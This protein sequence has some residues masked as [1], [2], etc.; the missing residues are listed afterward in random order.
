MENNN[1]KNK[2]KKKGVGK[3]IALTAVFFVICF[4]GGIA[5][6][7]LIQPNA[8]ADTVTR[9]SGEKLEFAL[10]AMVSM[11]VSYILTLIIHEGGH[12][13][14]GLATG[15]KFL[16]FRVF[17]LTLVKKDGKFAWKRFSIQGT[18]GQ[19]ILM[20]PED[21]A[22][23]KAPFLFYHLGGGLF[24]FITAA[25]CLPLVKGISAGIPKTALAVL[26]VFSA[27]QGLLNLIPMKIQVPNDG[28][29]ILMMIRN[30]ADRAAIYKSLY[31]NG[32]LYRGMSPR[33][34]P[35]E[36]YDFGESGFYKTVS[37]VL[38]A[39]AVLDSHDYE[40]AEKLFAEC[41]E[42]N[43][44]PVYNLE[45]R[46]ELMFCKVMNGAPAEEIDALFDKELQNYIKAAGKTMISKRRQMYAYQLIFKHDAAAAEKEY[47]AAMKMK[48]TYPIEGE[49]KSELGLIEAVRERAQ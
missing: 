49:L 9:T 14:F 23:E 38:S 22:P 35:A 45:S 20:P 19:C 30:P 18:G 31:L 15:Y 44:I 24:N 27:V 37:K 39:G 46:T 25:I 8:A 34:I 3:K 32:L 33:E 7:K 11:F 10:T 21:T 41:A 43:S 16:S 40:T 13:V 12:L 47:E 17:S 5:M 2:N 26:G 28:Y 6:G 36:Y 42:D 1:D 48:E 29:N 4:A